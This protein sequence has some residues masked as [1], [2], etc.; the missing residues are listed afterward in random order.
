MVAS[1][2]RLTHHLE[3]AV[4]GSSGHILHPSTAHWP[5]PPVLVQHAKLE[6]IHHRLW[7]FWER[8]ARVREC[9]TF[10]PPTQD[11]KEEEKAAVTHE[12]GR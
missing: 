1:G 10:S 5:Y 6:S 4:G 11:P 9:V 8:R 7:R 3:E 2:R 12:K